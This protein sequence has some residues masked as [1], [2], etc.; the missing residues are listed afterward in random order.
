[1]SSNDIIVVLRALGQAAFQNAMDASA[2]SVE[3]VGSAAKTSSKEVVDAGAQAKSTTGSWKGHAKAIAGAALAAGGLAA[4]TSFVKTATNAAVDLGEEVNKASVVF[5]GSEKPLVQW[6]KST[7]SS[8]GIA[9]SQALQAAGTFGNMLVPMGFAR[10]DA[11]SMS[12]KMVS[13]S[14]D[15][16]SFNNASPEDTLEALR[17]GLAGESE[18]LRKFGVFLSDARLKQEALSQGIYKGKG[19]L[20]AQAKA[21]ATYALILKDT[22]DAQG[23][24]QR[25]SG[26]LANQ[27]RIL[28]AQYTN[29]AATIGTAVIPIAT[30]LATGLS[31]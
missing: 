29:L 11:A 21:Q 14:A 31:W 28:K 30:K 26:S 3:Q 25:T 18:P 8:L 16:A 24:F 9:R 23:D 7:A 15:M 2:T 17:A 20:D 13:L 1:M 19:P 22:K 10:K 27:Q 4:A 6:S 12:Q 5:R